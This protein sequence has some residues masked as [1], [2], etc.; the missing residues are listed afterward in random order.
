MKIF[1]TLLV[2]IAFSLLSTSFSYADAAINTKDYFISIETT[3]SRIPVKLI[4]S[5]IPFDKTYDALSDNDKATLRSYYEG[6]PADNTPPFP[7]AGLKDIAQDIKEAHGKMRKK[8]PLFA[9]ANVDETGKVSKVAVYASPDE[10]MTQLISAVL[11]ETEFNPG[12][13]AGAPCAM[14]FV[15]DWNLLPVR[16]SAVI[17]SDKKN[18]SSR[19]KTR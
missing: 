15:L 13:C 1:Q 16:G 18:R 4:K 17:D 2:S 9:V 6:M 10:K 3:G 19:K 11:W 5:S 7:A 8:G 14:E 12:Q